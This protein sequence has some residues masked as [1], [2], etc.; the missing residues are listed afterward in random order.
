MLWRIETNC[1][2]NF[3]CKQ[4]YN[5]EMRTEFRDTNNS[6]EI[7]IRPV[8]KFYREE[9]NFILNTSQTSS[10]QFS[11]LNYCKLILN[12]FETKF[13]IF[14]NN[15]LSWSSFFYVTLTSERI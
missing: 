10:L 12:W 7:K 4:Y 11:Y 1:E 15:G 14:F 3:G 6:I 9:K 2:K 8:F 5:I 13:E